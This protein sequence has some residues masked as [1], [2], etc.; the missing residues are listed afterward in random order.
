MC[1]H[2]HLCMRGGQK[3]IGSL[4]VDPGILEMPSFLD[5]PQGPNSSPHNYEVSLCNQAT[6]SLVAQTF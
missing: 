3:K 6:N 5:G 4:R 2:M 1:V